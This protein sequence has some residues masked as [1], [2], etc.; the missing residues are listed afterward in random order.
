MYGARWIPGFVLWI[1][2]LSTISRWTKPQHVAISQYIRLLPTRW[3]HRRIRCHKVGGRLHNLR[4]SS[5]DGRGGGW[6]R[7]VEP[8]QGTQ[9]WTSTLQFAWTLSRPRQTD[10]RSSHVAPVSAVSVLVLVH[11]CCSDIQMI[12][13]C[14]QINIGPVAD[15]PVW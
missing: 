3:W 5:N 15:G 12:C 4:H 9:Q 13:G 7:G 14:C 1:S 2:F 10:V 11:T 6:A 8:L